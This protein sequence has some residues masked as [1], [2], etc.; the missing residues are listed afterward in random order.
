[1]LLEWGKQKSNELKAKVWLK[2]TPKAIPVYERHGWR[3]VEYFEVDLA[4]YG[5]PELYK[6]AW[7]VRDPA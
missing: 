4:K 6:R 3:I 1:L 7:M 2:A 5:D